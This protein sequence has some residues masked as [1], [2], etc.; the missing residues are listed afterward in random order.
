MRALLPTILLACLAGCSSAQPR[1][2]TSADT[3]DDFDAPPA[4]AVR[5]QLGEACPTEPPPR[6]ALRFCDDQGRIS[7]VLLPVD[8]LLGVP[9][10]TATIARQEPW[11]TLALEGDRLWI[12]RVTCAKCRRVL[13]F[14]FGGDLPR[15]RDDELREVQARLGLPADPVLRTADAWREAAARIVEKP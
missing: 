1:P 8:A 11:L 9:P 14:S 4:P 6:R 7:G 15:M 5:A 13:G 2:E 3:S 10:A 12:R